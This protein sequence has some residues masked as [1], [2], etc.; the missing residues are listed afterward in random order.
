MTPARFTRSL[1]VIGSLW[2]ILM[3]LWA[4]ARQVH[5]VSVLRGDIVWGIAFAQAG[6]ALPFL[7]ALLLTCL[8]ALA[9]ACVW[10]EP[11]LWSGL[12]WLI[13]GSVLGYGLYQTRFSVG[14]LLIPSVLLLLGAGLITLAHRFLQ[15]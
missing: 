3:L 4:A 6:D 14:P 13:T 8:A 9:A 10:R 7:F 12:A 11:T 15:P 1:S 5:I 2:G